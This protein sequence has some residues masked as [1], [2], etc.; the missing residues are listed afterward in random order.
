MARF[1]G[2]V[3]QGAQPAEVVWQGFQ[4]YCDTDQTDSTRLP[5]CRD[6][7]REYGWICNADRFAAA[8]GLVMVLTQNLI[9][10]PIAQLCHISHP[11]T[12]R[13]VLM[14]WL[15][16]SIPIPAAIH[17]VHHQH[18]NW[19]SMNKNCVSHSYSVTL[20]TCSPMGGISDKLGPAC[21]RN[22]SLRAHDQGSKHL[23]SHLLRCSC[24]Q[25]H[26]MYVPE[27]K[28]RLPIADCCSRRCQAGVAL[29]RCSGQLQ[30]RPDRTEVKDLSS[31][32]LLCCIA[33]AYICE[34]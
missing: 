23:A 1:H 19:C 7:R 22:E 12:S 4:Q 15:C 5:Q 30:D 13:Q 20:L 24:P 28:R 6:D 18:L 14:L 17:P 8:A 3:L 25:N 31:E 32:L 27:P 21:I 10:V 11:V 9:G 26:V 2:P 34:V 33:I 16:D 29:H